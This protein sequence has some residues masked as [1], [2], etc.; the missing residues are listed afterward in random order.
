MFDPG[1]VAI[2]GR[3]E[4]AGLVFVHVAGIPAFPS[5]PVWLCS[6]PCAIDEHELISPSKVVALGATTNA[7]T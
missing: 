3:G 2:E 7:P 1:A 5:V 4:V 6:K